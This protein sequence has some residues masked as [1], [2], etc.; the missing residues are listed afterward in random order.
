MTPTLTFTVLTAAF[1]VAVCTSTPPPPRGSNVL[2]VG[3]SASVGDE[4]S[5]L[6]SA[7]K[8]RGRTLTLK[9]SSASSIPLRHDGE[10]IYDAVV[11][12]APQAALQSKLPVSRLMEFV[13]SGR[14]LFVASD[15][16]Y[17]SYTEKLVE[18]IGVDLDDRSNIMVDYQQSHNSL[19]ISNRPF[20][21]AGGWVDVAFSPKSADS[22]ARSNSDRGTCSASDV[23]FYGSGATIFKDNELVQP[24]LWGSSSSFGRAAN[25]HTE[26]TKVP[27]VA[28]TGA[29]LA[30]G[31]CTRTGSRATWFGSLSALSD[32]SLERA[33][34]AHAASV[35]QMLLWAVGESGQLRVSRFAHGRVEDGGAPDEGGPSDYRVKDVIELAIQVEEWDG[36]SAQ[37]VPFEA[38]DIQVEFVM[39]DPWV[40]TRL[41]LQPG[42]EGI[43]KA[44][45]QVPDQI[46]VYKFKIEYV[47]PGYSG[48]FLV[49]NVAVRPF[50]H[51]EYERFIQ[52]A[53]PYY[54]ASFSM[55]IGAF[56]LGI[57]LVFGG[58]DTAWLSGHGTANR[59]KSD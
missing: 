23:V 26:M 6:L 35:K 4:Y 36:A 45:I 7:L 21:T 40:R 37:W 25:T 52:M 56:I 16:G 53:S 22:V 32:D 46:G 49:K 57:A 13:D 51:N 43:Y 8:D 27:R 47:R 29:V 34:D 11:M 14:D 59:D 17:S 33:G 48:I 5:L 30:A 12:L 10:Y 2:V 41:Q 42:S 19:N 31:V 24:L 3:E 9:G 55:M 20:I 44:K 54:L 18:A 58:D 1:L 50:F 39:M 15:V 38:S 28:G